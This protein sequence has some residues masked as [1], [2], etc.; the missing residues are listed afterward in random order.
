MPVSVSIFVVVRNYPFFRLTTGVSCQFVDH[1]SR[2]RSIPS[3][4]PTRNEPIKRLQSS[5][6]HSRRR[7]A[8]P[9]HLL[10]TTT[11][12]SSPGPSTSVVTSPRPNFSLMDLRLP[13]I[14]GELC[15]DNIWVRGWKYA[16]SGSYYHPLSTLSRLL[17]QLFPCNVS[18]CIY[19]KCFT[20]LPY[21]EGEPVA[22]NLAVRPRPNFPLRH[23]PLK[24]GKPF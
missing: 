15:A 9:C 12:S 8:S 4:V 3:R 16:S 23:C 5:Y 24:R 14:K 11:N 2:A 19:Y 18:I 10:A 22:G 20:A 7:P 6:S 13:Q 21:C 17:S 1:R